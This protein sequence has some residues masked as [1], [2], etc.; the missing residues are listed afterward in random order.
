MKEVYVVMCLAGTEIE[1]VFH[2]LH[3]AENYI[4]RQSAER[5]LVV[6]KDIWIE[7]HFVETESEPT[8]KELFKLAELIDN[9]DERNKYIG[10]LIN[11][12]KKMGI[13][14]GA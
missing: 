13:K 11:E 14:N 3:S 10:K 1:R 7:K 2:N 12:V 6:E 9:P 5:G 4:M 8:H